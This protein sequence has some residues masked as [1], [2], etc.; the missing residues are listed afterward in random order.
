[1]AQLEIL[2]IW[3]TL[4][5]DQVA[6]QQLLSRPESFRLQVVVTVAARYEILQVHAGSSVSN[7]RVAAYQRAPK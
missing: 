5:G 6:G 2:G 7:L 4:A 3:H 1:M